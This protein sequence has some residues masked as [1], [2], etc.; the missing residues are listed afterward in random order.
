MSDTSDTSSECAI[1]LD[2]LKSDDLTLACNHRL[3][4]TCLHDY[5]EFSNNLACPICDRDI[6]NIRPITKTHYMC[7]S[8][9]TLWILLGLG[10]TLRYILV[11]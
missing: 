4:K 10:C 7:A 5:Q 1:C 9:V 8:F 6:G 3:H 2:T 11:D